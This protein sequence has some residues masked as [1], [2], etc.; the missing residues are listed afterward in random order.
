M[1]EPT[2]HAGGVHAGRLAEPSAS[3]LK[4]IRQVGH[5]RLGSVYFM[6]VFLEESFSI[7][8]DQQNAAQGGSRFARN[9]AAHVC[10][11]RHL[12]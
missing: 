5:D 9:F 4:R 2:Y 10:H 8:R 7:A 1:R 6:Q 11:S 12:K 3:P